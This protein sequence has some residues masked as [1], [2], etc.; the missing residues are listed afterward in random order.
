VGDPSD[1][2]TPSR[3]VGTREIHERVTVVDGAD[4]AQQL[5]VGG[6]LDDV[7]GRAGQ[8]R[9][10]QVG[11]VVVHREHEHAG[12]RRGQPQLLDRLSEA[13]SGHGEVE[14][15]D[16]GR[17]RPGG[18]DRLGAVPGLAD[19]F[20]VGLGV[21]EQLQAGSENGVVVRDEDADAR[22]AATGRARAGGP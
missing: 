7:A 11:R 15:H 21:D 13:G 19:R 22:H 10:A 16:I 14:Q 3:F 2:V 12:A 18:A 1:L 8:E 4:R 5:D 9:G 17:G 6:L 20:H